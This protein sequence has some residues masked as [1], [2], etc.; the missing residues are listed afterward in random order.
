MGEE[1]VAL[2]MLKQYLQRAGE[3]TV[4]D[5][6]LVVRFEASHRMMRDLISVV[7]GHIHRSRTIVCHTT[8]AQFMD[9]IFPLAGP[10]PS[11][12][13][14]E[15]CL[16]HADHHPVTLLGHDCVSSLQTLNIDGNLG[17]ELSNVQTELLTRLD[18]FNPT[19]LLPV[20][21]GQLLR[22]C[23][24][25]QSLCSDTLLP[26]VTTPIHL[27]HLTHL[28]TGTSF[29]LPASLISAPQLRHLR[30]FDRAEGHT[31]DVI[32]ARFEELRTVEIAYVYAS[33]DD[34]IRFLRSHSKLVAITLM[35]DRALP[36]LRSLARRYT[37]EREAQEVILTLETSRCSCPSLRTEIHLVVP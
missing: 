16:V 37:L 31:A 3:N 27:P 14:L 23:P 24:N 8:V 28:V 29:P 30:I 36:I 32:P 10:F 2:E 33:P 18:I 25:L 26:E 11:L 34:V 15:V 21:F 7:L 17:V 35:F 12:E 20:A 13:N 6:H 9:A 19:A 1:V 4:I 22:R 5:L